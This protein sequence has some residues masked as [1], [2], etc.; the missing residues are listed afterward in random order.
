MEF[1]HL[2]FTDNTPNKIIELQSI[3]LSLNQFT[4]Y[5][6]N[7][8]IQSFHIPIDVRNNPKFLL[9]NLLTSSGVQLNIE[10]EFFQL[11][12]RV[13]SISD[14]IQLKKELSNHKSL[15]SRSKFQY[16]QP[17]SSVLKNLVDNKINFLYTEEFKS[18]VLNLSIKLELPIHIFT[19]ESINLQK[20]K[21]NQIKNVFQEQ[22][23]LR[24]GNLKSKD[25]Y[26]DFDLEAY[27]E[28][29]LKW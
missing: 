2:Y 26:S 13:L 29:E 5:F 28:K 14:Q 10:N 8:P 19:T 24:S 16:S 27:F 18:E 15:F 21:R 11:N 6:Y 4:K 22:V 12:N 7:S 25:D 23:V 17:Y 3:S 1:A 9:S 20:K